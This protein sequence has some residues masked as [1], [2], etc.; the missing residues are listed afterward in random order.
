MPVAGKVHPIPLEEKT[1]KEELVVY[2]NKL[3]RKA[4]TEVD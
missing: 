4:S 2:S 1:S 3:V